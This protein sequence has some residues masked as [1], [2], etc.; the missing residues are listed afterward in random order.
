[1]GPLFG[2]AARRSRYRARP[3]CHGWLPRVLTSSLT[4]YS[5]QNDKRIIENELEGF[6]IRLNKKP[7]NVVVRKKDRGG[8]N[9]TNVGVVLPVCGVRRSSLT[10]PLIPCAFQTVP[11]TKLDNDE[12]RAVLSE[13]R[14][15]NADVAFRQDITVEELIE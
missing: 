15:S 8:I 5:L 10:G 11:L 3:A 14:I 12:I 7:P 6:G 4:P 13:Y 2:R 9:I 1:M